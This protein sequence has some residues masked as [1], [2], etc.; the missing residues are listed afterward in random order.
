MQWLRESREHVDV[1]RRSS[2]E[3]K[4]VLLYCPEMS[5]TAKEIAKDSDFGK[6]FFLGN[7]QWDHFP[8]GFPNLF[9]HNIEQI[10]GRD[11]VMLVSLRDPA[12]IL[13]Q[14]SVM[15]ALPRYLVK[16]LIVVLPYFPTGTMER[17]DTEG[18]IATAY[19][20]ARM[21]SAIPLTSRGPAKLIIYDIHTLQNRFYFGESVIPLLVTAIPLVIERIKAE[22]KEDTISIAF[23]DEGAQKRFGKVFSECNGWDMIICTKVREGNK[24]IVKI[25]E[26]DVEGRHVIIVDDLVQT[27]GTL[28]ECKNALLARGAVCVSAYVTHAVFPKESWKRFTE[29]KESNGGFKTFYI[30]DSIPTTAHLLHDKKP[31]VVI[32]LAGSI[33][34]NV[35]RY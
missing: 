15:Y 11:V 16:S 35:L 8:D 28:I 26:G 19:T 3:R 2:G 4:C 5:Q 18:Q 14:L 29:P 34:E 17:V 30:T 27:G 13:E 32:P 23:P 24:R 12:Q 20:L 22:Y 33:A 31:F 1:T 9:L 6:Y 10:R 21:L 25:K 7:I